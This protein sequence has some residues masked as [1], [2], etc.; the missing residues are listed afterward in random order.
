M[1]LTNAHGL[2]GS[3]NT[4]VFFY[5]KDGPVEAYCPLPFLVKLINKCCGQLL[6]GWMFFLVQ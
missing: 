6:N 2:N 5:S 3:Q 1:L 4:A